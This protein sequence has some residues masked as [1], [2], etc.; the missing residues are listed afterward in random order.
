VS[1]KID[2]HVDERLDQSHTLAWKMPVNAP[3]AELV[4]RDAE[5]EWG[6]HRYFVRQVEKVRRNGT[7]MLDVQCDALWYRLGESQYIGTISL[8]NVDAAS[9]LDI[10][11][12]GSGWTRG[13]L[14][15]ATDLTGYTM[16][17]QDLTHL[18]L[19]RRWAS[20]CGLHVVF[21]TVTRKVDL[22]AERGT[23]RGVGFRYGRNMTEI[24][25]R[26]TA[27]TATVL[28]AY[29][30]DGLN[31]AGL[32]AG[33]E[34]VEDFSFYTDQ[35][36]TLEEA[37][38]RFTKRRAVYDDR[39]LD[40]VALYAYAQRE[41]LEQSQGTVAYEIRVVDLEELIG[42]EDAQ[43]L[44]VGDVV[45]V[46]DDD[47][48]L[49]AQTTVVRRDIYPEEPARNVIELA[50]LPRAPGTAGASSVR[51]SSALSWLMDKHD[52]GAEYRLRNNG[53]YQ[54]NRIPLRFREGEA[55]FGY[56]LFATGVGTGS[57]SVSAYNAATDELLHRA[58]TIP[59]TNG[60][61]I[62]ENLTWAMKDLAGVLDVRIRM[63]ATA[64]PAQASAGV[65]IAES[66]SRLW[67]HYYGAV[68]ETPASANSVRYDYEE[69]SAEV[70]EVQT[71]TVPDNVFSILIE[72]HA[73]SG[74]GGSGGARIMGRGGK[75]VGRIDVTP[76]NVFDVV[77]GGTP[78][79]HGSITVAGWPDGGTASDT[80]LMN[81]GGGGGSTSIR[82]QGLT[83]ADSIIVAGGGGGV[84]EKR[85]SDDTVH[86]AGDGGFY[87]GGNAVRDGVNPAVGGGTGATQF[88]P[89]AQGHGDGSVTA[90]G[91]GQGGDG[92]QAGS[93][94]TFGGGGG[95]GGW[96]GG[97]GG[98][99]DR[100][101]G[102]GSGWVSDDVYD[103][104]LDDGENEGNGYLI[105]SWD[106]PDS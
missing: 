49:A 34:Y 55:F 96:Y 60:Q 69:V 48:G 9:G 42:T 43:S 61:V 63:V 84:G 27:P 67:V 78:G 28:Y 72:A 99:D 106:S 37:R 17:E 5:V 13:D 76:G 4:I 12:D 8:G 39:F 23:N 85:P 64:Q 82:P 79:Q 16:E 35:G 68:R 88:A 57:L 47:L 33:A 46:Q 26:V 51:P 98:G 29:G 3:K 14:T 24:L 86:V 105:I 62:H 92:Y 73:A 83:F 31:I 90:P 36:L 2:F 44:R 71:F 87:A 95:G 7:A 70:G 10:I 38:E 65:D 75:V 15:D 104:E 100:C 25:Q 19:V 103:L 22:V 94:F 91:F 53:T 21:D 50:Y 66:E 93:F 80:F 40:D 52:N 30:R 41:V 101:G 54:V 6:N 20:I 45:R 102:G 89:G 11:L 1:S 56:D 77:V 18:A 59:Y 74:Y 81:G 58:I 32:N 97:G